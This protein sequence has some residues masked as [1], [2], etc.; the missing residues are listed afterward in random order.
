[1][2]GDTSHIPGSIAA[3]GARP[4]ARP[5]RDLFREH[6]LRHTR[7]RDLVYSTLVSLHSHPT[8]EELHALVNDHDQSVSLA[9]VY[10]TLDAL[11]RCGLL[12]RIPSQV[13]GG[14]C[15]F[16]ADLSRHVHVVHPEGTILDVPAD[17]G[18]PLL[19]SI[20]KDAIAEVERRMGVKVVGVAVHL[21]TAKAD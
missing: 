17:L 8:A 11:A 10:N 12:R 13:G 20:D 9:T 21:V 7:Q 18:D 14:A 19:T 1:M 5:V 2:N 3:R 4:L 16:D 15:R 6:R